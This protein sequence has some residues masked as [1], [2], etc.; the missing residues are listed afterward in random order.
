MYHVGKLLFLTKRNDFSILLK[1][2][3]LLSL[4]FQFSQFDQSKT[5][6]SHP[7]VS[8]RQEGERSELE[9]LLRQVKAEEA[10]RQRI[11]T[12]ISRSDRTRFARLVP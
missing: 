9:K 11:N 8:E 12:P 6:S 2:K 5:T 10:L 3:E 7:I 1:D 4:S